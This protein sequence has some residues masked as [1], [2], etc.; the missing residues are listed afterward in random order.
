MNKQK[1]LALILA[2]I[3]PASAV[4]CKLRDFGNKSSSSSVSSSSSSSS[5][6]SSEPETEDETDDITSS[7]T[8]SE[9]ETEPSKPSSGNKNEPDDDDEYAELHV[10]IQKLIDDLSVSGKADVVQADIDQLLADYDQYYQDYSMASLGYYENMNDEDAENAYDKSYE[11][12]Y[13]FD[14]LVIYA[15]SK[16]YKNKE[17]GSLFT[18]LVDS[19]TADTYGA[20]SM[21]MSKVEGY[22]KVDFAENDAIIDEYYDIYF[23]EDLDSDEKALKCAELYL[24]ILSEYDTDLFYTQYNREYTGDDIKK[25]SKKVSEKLIDTD[26]KLIDALI[27]ADGIEELL[28]SPVEFDDPI[29]ELKKYASKL[30]PDIKK[31]AEKL[32]DDEL[33][34]I[35]EN[36]NAFPGSFTLDFPVDNTAFIFI[37]SEDK[38][39]ILPTAVHEFGHFCASFYDKIPAYLAAN[40]LDIAETQSQGFE[41]LFMQYYDD[42]YGDQ[43]DLMRL[44]KTTNMLEAVICSF[45]IGEF[46]YKV[47]ENIDTITPEEVIEYWHDIVS[48]YWP[49]IE[50][51]EINH[52]FENPGYYISYGVS[53]LAAFDIWRDVIVSPD[54]ALEKYEKIMKISPN[55]SDISFNKAIKDCGFNNVL[56]EKYIDDLAADL[57]KYADE[58]DK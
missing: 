21:T 57:L 16:G 50:F 39:E 8:S 25:L 36:E 7:E 17:Y 6:S 29:G 33:Y 3:M 56:D 49:D 24:D 55:D 20:R 41:M 32:T 35:S 45:L 26:D 38:S 14:Q 12:M 46:E 54:K 31:Y 1:L 44:Y 51:Y 4:S 58:Y 11:K 23:D 42:L 47:L 22:A 37:H 34:S 10:N 13:V 18:D 48:D 15:F 9:S 30:S 43:A 5:A 19:E 2:L 27:D 40:D 28:D 53:A 52:L